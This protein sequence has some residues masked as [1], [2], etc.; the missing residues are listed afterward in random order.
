MGESNHDKGV[1]GSSGG[2]RRQTAIENS[3]VRADLKR[4][5]ELALQMDGGEYS[6]ERK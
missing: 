3:G 6:T 2:S 4:M 1:V 5:R